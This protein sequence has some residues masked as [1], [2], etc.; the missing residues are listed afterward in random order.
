MKQATTADYQ[1][2]ASRKSRCFKKSL[3]FG[4]NRNRKKR[5]SAVSALSFIRAAEKSKEKS[6]YHAP[7]GAAAAAQALIDSQ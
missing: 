5:K 2:L 4:K 6:I 7:D 3:F 1:P